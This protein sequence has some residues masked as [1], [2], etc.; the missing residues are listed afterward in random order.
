M[1]EVLEQIESL[2][3]GGGHYHFES[4]LSYGAPGNS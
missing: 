1:K 2:R 4:L 3:P